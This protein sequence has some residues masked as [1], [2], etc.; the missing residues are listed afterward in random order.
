MILKKLERYV[1][2]SSCGRRITPCCPSP[3]DVLG[4]REKRAPARRRRR[5]RPPAR[6]RPEVRVALDEFRRA[7]REPEHVF[8]DQNLPVAGRA[9]ADADGRDRTA[10]VSLRAQRLGDRLDDDGEG[11][12]SATATRIRLERAPVG[13]F[14]PLSAEAAPTR[15]I[16]CGVRPTCA[17]TGMPRSTTKAMVSAMRAPPS[18]LMAPQPVSFITR[19]AVQ[20][21]LFLRRLVRTERH[22][23]D[24]QRAL[25]GASPR[26]PAGSSCR[27]LPGW[28]VSSPCITMP[29][30]SPTRITSQYLSTSRAVWA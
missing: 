26:A 27:A 10:A 18:S 23:D 2:R 5:R 30:E 6:C 19:A 12:G 14:A 22:V 28:C 13:L 7:R 29:S 20:E 3:V 25:I 4:T 16:D 11:A 17:I 9:G 1:R 8:Q 24:H 21:R 15:L